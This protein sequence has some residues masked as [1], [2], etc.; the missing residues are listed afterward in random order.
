[1]LRELLGVRVWSLAVPQ[2]VHVSPYMTS[3]RQ[4]GRKPVGKVLES[5]SVIPSIYRK[6]NRGVVAAAYNPGETKTGGSWGGELTSQPA[7]P[8]Q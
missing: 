3:K 5:L 4:M 1:M 6:K 7:Y 8:N 2:L